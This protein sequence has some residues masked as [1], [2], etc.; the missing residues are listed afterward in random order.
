MIKLVISGGQT[1]SDQAGWRAA[2]RCGIAT[3]GWMPRGWRTEE[4]GRPD[5]GAEYG[6]KEYP[7]SS[8]YPPRTYANAKGSDV[9]LWFGQRDSAGFGC[10][11]RACRDYGK[12]I[13]TIATPEERPPRI[14][15]TL[16][17]RQGAQVINIA[18]NRESKSP[19]IGSWVESYLVE[20]FTLLKG[21]CGAEEQAGARTPG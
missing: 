10:T 18:G 16:I 14:I 19:G 3:A 5:L 7:L 15:A 11:A 4:G 21:G 9:T 2:K 8:G 20:L 17:E 12:P 6:A 13:W 1:G